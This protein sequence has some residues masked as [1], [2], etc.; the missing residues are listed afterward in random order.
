[1]LLIDLVGQCFLPRGRLLATSL[2]GLVSQCFCLRGC[3]VVMSLVGLVGQCFCPRGRHVA[4][5]L[6]SLVGQCFLLRG[7]CLLLPFFCHSHAC[8]AFLLISQAGESGLTLLPPCSC[9][10]KADWRQRRQSQRKMIVVA[11]VRC[12]WVARALKSHAV[13]A[14]SWRCMSTMNIVAAILVVVKSRAWLAASLLLADIFAAN[15]SADSRQQCSLARDLPAD[16]LA[17]FAALQQRCSSA[18][19][20]TTNAILQFT[21]SWRVARSLRRRFVDSWNLLRLQRISPMK[22]ASKHTRPGACCSGAR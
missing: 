16:T 13:S 20:V 22:V 18:N 5:L 2:V 14:I 11:A 19:A 9:L 1:M 6:V 17:C 8:A 12:A 7:H 21:D 3:L 10:G 4:T 15:T